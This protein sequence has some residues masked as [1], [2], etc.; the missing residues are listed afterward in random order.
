MPRVS[1]PARKKPVEAQEIVIPGPND[2]N[3]PPDELL[4]YTICL[5]GTKGIGKTTLAASIPGCLT[6]MF[7]P[8]R[9]N[10]RIRQINLDVLEPDGIKASGIDAWMQF[11]SIVERTR[12]DETVRCY[13][14]DT[15]DRAYEACLNHHC[16][17]NNVRHPGG[18]NDFGALWGIIKDDFE[19]TM[20]A[21]RGAGKG[22]I[23]T[24]HTKESDVEI[25]TGGKVIQYG[26]SCGGAPLRY[27]KAACDYAFFYGYS[28]DRRR[29]IH[30]RNYETI[31]TACGV[32][33]RFISPSGKPLEAIEIPQGEV[34]GWGLI[35][36]AFENK[37][38]DAYEETPEEAENKPARTT[39]RRS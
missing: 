3:I 19:L 34:N 26:P 15:A 12:E 17:A 1:L 21:I 25:I 28:A 9:K 4:D 18:L 33:D 32:P 10:L 24:S 20:N 14:V 2:L 6:I 35:Q 11:K 27:I 37:V 8:L 7:E 38:Y 16:L 23:L 31:W 13:N 36:A 5:Y 22:L 39:R 29:L 30:L